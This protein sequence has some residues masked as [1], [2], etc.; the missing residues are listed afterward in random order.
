MVIAFLINRKSYIV[1]LRQP[2]LAAVLYEVKYH[3]WEYQSIMDQNGN[4][5]TIIIQAVSPPEI[6]AAF[7]KVSAESTD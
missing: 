4:D 1:W 7:R 2:F 5:I 6:S 3:L